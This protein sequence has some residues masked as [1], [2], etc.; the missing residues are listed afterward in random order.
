MFYESIYDKMAKLI[1][2]AFVLLIILQCS[3]EVFT[4]SNSDTNAL[5][6]MHHSMLDKLY[7]ICFRDK[8]QSSTID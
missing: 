5:H 4:P 2:F 3:T 1:D 7:K 6:Q 8:V